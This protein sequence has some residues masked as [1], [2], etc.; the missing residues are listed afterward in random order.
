ML[1]NSKNMELHPMLDS[2]TTPNT[3]LWYVLS[4]FGDC[5]SIRVG[6]TVSFV[7]NEEEGKN[8]RLFVIGGANPSG[9]FCDTFVLDL[10]T[11]QWDMIDFP[12]FRARYE[13]AA[14]IPSS[15]PDKIYIFGGA[16]QTGNMNDI[17]VLDTKNNSWSTPSVSGTP[18]SPRTYHTTA[19]AGDN[20]IVYSGGHS[21]PDPVADR[22]VYSFNASTLTWTKLNVKGDSP[23]ARHGHVSVAVGNKFYIHG[24][25]AGSSF[26]DDIHVLDLDKKSWSNIKRKKVYPSARAAHSCTAVGT[27]LYL[28][29]GMNRDGALDDLYKFDTGKATR[30]VCNC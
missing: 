28:F 1:K 13:H 10:N 9:A 22:Q 17:Q 5:P 26:Y 30:L 18:P 12:G 23:K 19:I 20:F 8:G 29:G 24:G 7:K 2:D 16:D 27:D 11:M 14:F 3:G 15:Q 4:T 25:M 6:H 21:G